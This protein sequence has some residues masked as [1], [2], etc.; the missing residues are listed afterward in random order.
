MRR[1]LRLQVVFQPVR[2]SAD[3]LRNAYQFVLPITQREARA[4]AAIHDQPQDPG[5]TRRRREGRA[6]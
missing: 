3:H 2:L 4:G 6:A 5:R 1:H